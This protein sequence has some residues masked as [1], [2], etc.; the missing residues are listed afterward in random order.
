[1][2]RPLRIE[3][4]GAVYHVIAR[5]NE[6]KSYFE[7][8]DDKELLLRLFSR[9]HEKHNFV[10]YAYCIMD[11]HYHLLLETPDGNLSKGMHYINSIFA[12]QFNDRHERSG[13][14][15][16]G[17]YKSFLVQKESY[18]LAVSRYIV[19][20]PVRSGTVSHPA[21]YQWSSYRATAGMEPALDFLTAGV[22][23]SEF[24]DDRRMA[25]EE[26][27]QFILGGFGLEAPRAYRNSNILGDKNFVEKVRERLRGKETI[28]EVPRRERFLNRPALSEIF[29][30]EWDR[31]LKE[32]RD[33]KIVASVSEYGYSQ[34]EIARHLGLHYSTVSLIVKRSMES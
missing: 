9:T 20:N 16:Q 1:M 13:H 6:K 21:Y 24:S 22:I 28:S 3:F 5:G 15:F 29:A 10:F 34:T 11:N 33:A 30:T 23:L 26:Y 4:P 31:L 8:N 17:R 2:S 7:S 14:L 12:Q 19:L 32:E 25:L 18:L 27:R